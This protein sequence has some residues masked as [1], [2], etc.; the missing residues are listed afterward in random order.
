M[1]THPIVRVALGEAVAD[2][3]RHST[4]DL[5]DQ[6]RPGAALDL[7]T[8]TEPVVLAYAGPGRGFTLPPGRF[9]SLDVDAGGV[10]GI[11]ASPHLASLPL[12]DA[13]ALAARIGGALAAAGWTPDAAGGP[14]PPLTAVAAAARADASGFFR[15]DLARWTAGGDEAT[16]RLRQVAGAANHRFQVSVELDNPEVARRL[17]AAARRR[18]EAA[19]TP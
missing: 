9:L 18:A 1:T 11:A 14:A 2:V 7:V 4:Y 8:V 10:V 3:A 17:A 13:L 5:S 12:D 15:A 16:V 19:A 6:L